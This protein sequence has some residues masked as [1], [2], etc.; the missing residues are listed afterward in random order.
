MQI[1]ENQKAI[2]KNLKNTLNADLLWGSANLNEAA[3][4]SKLL[5]AIDLGEEKASPLF[6]RIIVGEDNKTK[7]TCITLDTISTALNKTNFYGKFSKDIVKENG[8]FYNGN[9]DKTHDNIFNF[10]VACFD[11]LKEE[12][13]ND[14]DLGE[15]ENGFITINA[16]IYVLILLL[17]DIVNFLNENNTIDPKKHKLD[18]IVSKTIKYLQPI[19]NHFKI[20]SIDERLNYR[21]SYGL[22]GRTDY[23]HRLQKVIR[24]S[25]PTFNPASLKKYDDE[26]AQFLNDLAIKYIKGIEKHLNR[27]LKE[28]LVEKYEKNWWKKGVPLPVYKNAESLS[29]QKNREVEDEDEEIEPWNCLH[30][31]DYRD[32]IMHNKS[33]LL[34]DF[35]KQ[36]QD[37]LNAEAKTSWLVEFNKI[38]NDNVH[39]WVGQESQIKFLEEI[40]NWL[41][42]NDL[43][44]ED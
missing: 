2:P 37:Q 31:I 8:T 43:E 23:W 18:L 40:Y 3:R 38:R 27:V 22:S 4:A 42:Q 35:T 41:I 30:I 19:V 6:G 39:S 17:N 24:D 36:G 12:L 26:K 34:K 13:S 9:F 29:S 21:K 33:W 15:G 5:L 14:W 10:I 1:N 28:R 32:I 11:H 44:E 25:Y 16:T 7:R 20:I